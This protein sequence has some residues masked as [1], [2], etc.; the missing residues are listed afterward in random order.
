MALRARTGIRLCTALR[1]FLRERTGHRLSQERLRSTKAEQQPEQRSWSSIET[2]CVHA[3]NLHFAARID[4]IL[5][6][7]IQRLQSDQG[8]IT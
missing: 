7:S 2:H 1:L 8:A 6:V 4:L 3:A 5:P